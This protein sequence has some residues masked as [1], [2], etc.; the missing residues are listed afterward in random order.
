VGFVLPLQP[1]AA[2]KRARDLMRKA[3]A[4]VNRLEGAEAAMQ[5]GDIS[6]A[7][8]IF[9]R[10]AARRPST[11]TTETAKERLA[12]LRELA[13]QEVTAIDEHLAALGQ[14][15][16]QSAN[17]P[18]AVPNTAEIAEAFKDYAR[19]VRQF[20]N[21]PGI[22]LETHV[23][24]QSVKPHFAVVINE[25]SAR[26][27]WELGQQQE[28]EGFACC[29]VRVYEK[30][31]Q[32]VPAPSARS[33]VE[34]LGVLKKDPQVVASVSICRELE[35]CHRT[36]SKAER[37][38]EF[39]PTEARQLFTEIVRRAPKTSEVYRFARGQLR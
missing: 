30:A 18:Q 23:R 16:A 33:A 20:R 28:E 25:P 19:L 24:K 2:E 1:S 12:Q 15:Y 8:L 36:Y 26:Q 9:T 3:R 4:D 29:A 37:L 17:D 34:R 38:L 7:G 10:L 32:L 39:K 11:K 27:L 14:S 35:W 21:V 31:A 5:E 6:T 13:K 22:N